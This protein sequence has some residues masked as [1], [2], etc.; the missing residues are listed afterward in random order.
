MKD[1]TV[2]APDRP[3]IKAVLAVQ[4]KRLRADERRYVRLGILT[5]AECEFATT[6]REPATRPRERRPGPTRRRAL[7]RSSSRAGDGGE[8][9]E[10]SEPP[11]R[12][13]CA[14]CGKDIPAN[15]GPKAKYCSDKHAANAR[16]RRKRQHLVDED[17][18]GALLDWIMDGEGLTS[19][20]ERAL[21]E[22]LA[23][24]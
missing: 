14:L 6:P 23:A 7:A 1:T 5:P 13:L 21:H 12:R 9:G 17:A 24:V 20:Q 3:N 4:E 15:R 18:V 19:E 22:P 11:P 10:S 2:T 16:Q 8:D